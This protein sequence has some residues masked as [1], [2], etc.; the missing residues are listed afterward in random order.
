MPAIGR[1]NDKQKRVMK[2]TEKQ[3][4]RV[5]GISRL[6]FDTDGPGIRTLVLLSGCHL[7]CAYCLN[8]NLRSGKAGSLFE[9]EELLYRVRKDDIYFKAS[10]GGITFGGGEPLLHGGF[11]REFRQIC[12]PDWTITVETSLNVPK[13]DVEALLGSVDFWIVDI[14]DM[15][16]GKYLEYTGE[17]NEHVVEN[18]GL[19]RERIDKSKVLVRV[20][21]IGGLNTP[22]DVERSEGII[23]NM[24]FDTEVFEYVIPDHLLLKETGGAERLPGYLIP[25][26]DEVPEVK[27]EKSSLIEMIR[28]QYFQEMQRLTL[29]GIPNAEY[30]DDWKDEM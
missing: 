24:G 10:G 29:L 15:D 6:R 20:P 3:T 1:I 7:D 27:P 12:P 16:P 8:G 11:I 13:E 17:S 14:K 25:S 30:D 4:A 9:P 18:L 2:H 23:R 26:E 19:L 22:E 28:R 21:R 5:A